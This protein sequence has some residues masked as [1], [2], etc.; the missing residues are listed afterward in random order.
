MSPDQELQRRLIRENQIRGRQLPSQQT[1]PGT[2][3]LMELPKQQQSG[4]RR[5][6]YPTLKTGRLPA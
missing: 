2:R 5:R 6:A 1:G 3:L 4:G